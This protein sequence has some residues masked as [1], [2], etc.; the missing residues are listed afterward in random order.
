MGRKSSYVYDGMVAVDWMQFFAGWADGD[1]D[2]SKH[3]NDIE[4]VGPITTR[5]ALWHNP[6]D[7]DGRLIEMEP[8]DWARRGYDARMK[9][10]RVSAGLGPVPS[11]GDWVREHR[12]DDLLDQLAAPLRD[13][14]TVRRWAKARRLPVPSVRDLRA[15]WRLPHT[16]AHTPVWWVCRGCGHCWTATPYDRTCR[17]QRGGCP[18]CANRARDRNDDSKR[19]RRRQRARD[20]ATLLPEAVGRIRVPAG[21]MVAGT[22]LPVRRD[23][24]PV[25]TGVA[26]GA[27]GHLVAAL[28]LA[29]VDARERN[30]SVD[31][32]VPVRPGA[33]D[34]VGDADGDLQQERAR[35]WPVFRCAD[36]GHYTRPWGDIRADARATGTPCPECPPVA[37]P[38]PDDGVATIVAEEVVV[39]DMVLSW[40]DLA[41]GLESLGVTASPEHVTG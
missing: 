22:W 38:V 41:D 11:L 4:L 15:A 40:D 35:M 29:C 19:G 25:C 12:R 9:K 17:P 3:E 5:V 23:L 27:D 37:A 34:A 26:V 31:V 1:N 39:P 14:A 32:L 6:I 28:T 16:Y 21:A 18:A 33:P 2:P 36:H 20:R 8:A 24:T 7:V 13:G 10:A 30:V